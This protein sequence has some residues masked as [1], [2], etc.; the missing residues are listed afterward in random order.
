MTFSS[1]QLRLLHQAG[2]DFNSTLELAELL[3]RVF[4]RVM[5]DLDAEAGSIWLRQG[6]SLVCELAR[7]PVSDRIQGMELPWGAGIVGDVGRRGEPELVADATDDPRFVHQVDEATGF[8]TRSM[9]AAP[10]VAKGEVLGVFQLINRRSGDGRF[11]ESQRDLLQALGSTAGLAL[12]NARLMDAEKRARDLK[13]LLGISREINATLEVERLVLS[14]VN[15]ASQALSYDRA[16]IA[17]D[18]GGEPLVRAISG[19]ETVDPKAEDAKSLTALV[20]WLLERADTTYV[21]DVT[22]DTD[23]ARGFRNAFGDYLERRGVRSL[24]LL[25]LK[26]EQGRL[27]AFY[28]E[29]SSPAFLGDSGLE[30]SELLSNQVSVALRNAELYS[31][32]PFIGLLQPIAEWR[33][34]LVGMSGRRMAAR[35]GVPAFLLIAAA[36]FP[37][38]QRTSAQQAELLPAGRMP[39]R[40]TVGGL[41]TQVLVDEGDQLEAGAVLAVLRDDELD[42]SLSEAQA[43][44]ATAVRT[45]ASAR[46]R[47]DESAARV[48]QITADELAGRVG[49]LSE[50]VGRTRLRAPLKGVV[51]TMRPWERIGEWLD[52]G[53][54]FILLGSTDD[55]ELEARVP[56]RH[57]DRVRVGQEVRLK[58]EARPEN[59]FVAGVTEIAPQAEPGEGDA[60]PTFVVRA[61][62]DNSEELLRPGMQARA[63]IV[64]D[65]RPLGWIVIRPLVE[66]MQLRFWR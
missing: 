7:G 11:D 13:A 58:V 53:E 54:T 40:A 8:T 46:A 43:G 17:L 12:H 35:Y 61:R 19:Q 56:Q 27:G 14:V 22:A 24:A 51:L 5:E 16:A 64:G 26:D 6:D 28:M 10:L 2:L 49:L 9:V 50:Q 37:W 60:E 1:D 4:D 36:M 3:P 44:H 57:I 30:A 62:I 25:P 31:Q 21:E 20:T 65:R 45:A 63:K 66:W 29:S 33:G 42:I 41:V 32:T 23:E 55:L 38:K 47:G 48:A 34:R 52:A 59:T 15:L 18:E 39:V